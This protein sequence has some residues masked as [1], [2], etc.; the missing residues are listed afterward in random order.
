MIEDEDQI[1]EVLRARVASGDYLDHRLGLPGLYSEGGGAFRSM[2][3]GRLQRMFRRGT[4]EYDAAH[5]AGHLEPLPPLVPASQDAVHECEAL[6]GRRLPPLLRRC[7]LELGDGGFGPAYGLE[8]L[9]EISSDFQGQQRSWPGEWQPMTKTLLP[10]C[11]W[12]CAIT[13]FVDCASP[14]AAMWA[15][16]PNPAPYDNF[17]VALFPQHL[18]FAEW[19][20]RWIEGTLQQPWLVQ[21]EQTGQWRGATDAENEALDQEE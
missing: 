3:D 13:S 5:S 9:Q 7:Y 8:P 15:I 10:I 21:D 17:Q 18:S 1:F 16:D 2:D 11:N 14:T 6:V 4:P 19:M 12:G 20:R